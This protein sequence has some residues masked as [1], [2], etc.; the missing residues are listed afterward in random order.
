MCASAQ[1]YSGLERYSD[2]ADA[3]LQYMTLSPG[4][5]DGYVLDLRGDAL[6]AA[7]DYA[8]AANDYQASLQSPSLNDS[9]LSQMK[10]ARA[11]S[12][13][14]DYASALRLYDDASDQ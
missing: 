3:Y 4:I 5:I 11:T 2:A 10:L 9:I 1:S 6:F 7:G 8:G 12:L 13:S 14:G